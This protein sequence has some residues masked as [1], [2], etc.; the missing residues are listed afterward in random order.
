MVFE[1]K[2]V[3]EAQLP[4]FISSYLKRKGVDIEPKAS[5]MVAEFVGTDL[6][7]LTGELDKLIITMPSKDNNHVTKGSSKANP[8]QRISIMKLSM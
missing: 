2:K 4:A 6:S 1:S 3:R 5:Q 8:M 7:R